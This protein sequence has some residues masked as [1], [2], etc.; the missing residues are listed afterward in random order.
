MKRSHSVFSVNL[1]NFFKVNKF[2]DRPVNNLITTAT[3]IIQG[4]RHVYIKNVSGTDY[5]FFRIT[6]AAKLTRKDPA[7]PF[8]APRIMVVCHLIGGNTGSLLRTL[9]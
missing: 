3:I 8:T 4:G 9:T 7:A 1:I 5:L 2:D 6:N